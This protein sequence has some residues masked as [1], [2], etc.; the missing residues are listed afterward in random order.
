MCDRQQDSAQVIERRMQKA[1]DEM[2]H[3]P[4][5]DFIV[6]ND[7]FEDALDDLLAIFKSG[8][9]RLSRQIQHHDHLLAQLLNQA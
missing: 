4:E 8:R 1:R 6:I 7:D 5:Y 2:S 9:L 3:Y